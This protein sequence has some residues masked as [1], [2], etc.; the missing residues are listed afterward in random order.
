MALARTGADQERWKALTLAMGTS[1]ADRPSP[2]RSADLD[3]PTPELQPI[4]GFTL[5]KALVYAL[6][7]QESRFNP[8]AVSPVGA[9]GLMQVMPSSAAIAAGDDKL[10]RDPTPLLDPAFNLR[11]GQDYFS[12]LLDKGV[13]H[14]LI[15]AV[16]A[17]NAGPAPVTRTAQMLGPEADGLLLMECLPAQET[18]TYVQRVLAG[19]WT[20]RKMWGQASPSLDALASGQRAIDDRADLSQPNRAPTQLAAQ[21]LQI[22]MR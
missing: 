17:Y 11:V 3:Y 7:R 1:L 21:T 18:R 12:W 14:D 8:Q 13:G 5:D 4:S 19:Y 9:T 22:G 15:R 10:K 16:A 2:P 20:Y 6:V